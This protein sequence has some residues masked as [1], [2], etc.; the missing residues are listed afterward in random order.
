MWIWHGNHVQVI[1]FKNSIENVKNLGKSCFAVRKEWVNYNNSSWG[2][3]G[4]AGWNGL[5]KT[6][7]PWH[8]WRAFLEI[9]NR[10]PR[11]PLQLGPVPPPP[12]EPPPGGGENPVGQLVHEEAPELAQAGIDDVHDGE[13]L[14]AE[15]GLSFQGVAVVLVVFPGERNFLSSNKFFI[16]KCRAGHLRTWAHKKFNFWPC[17]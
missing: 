10:P 11:L 13:K 16:D 17:I 6:S 15:L 4:P 8:L 2:Q 3:T 14:E 5:I 7:R 9:P 1:K 12:L